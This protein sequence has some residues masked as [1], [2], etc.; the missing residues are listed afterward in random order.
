[1]IRI[2]LSPLALMVAHASIAACHQPARPS[3]ETVAHD[4][5]GTGLTTAVE[6]PSDGS[7]HLEVTPRWLDRHRC[8]VRVID[9]REPEELTGS[10]GHIDGAE[11][12]PI[13]AVP[14]AATSWN[15]GDPI[16]LVCKQG[17]RSHGTAVL[18]ESMGFS[19]VASLAGGME[20]WSRAGLAVSHDRLEMPYASVPLEDSPDWEKREAP[21]WAGS[22]SLSL[23]HVREHF[24]SDDLRWIQV[25]GLLL[26]GHENCVD[27]RED[28]PI[29]GTPGGDAGELLLLLATAERVNH[30]DFDLD[31]RIPALLTDYLDTFGQFYMHTDTHALENLLHALH[32]DPRFRDHVPAEG[33]MQHAELLVR[34]PP[35][36]LRPALMEHLLRP[37][38]VGCGHLRLILEHPEEY[39][40][41]V[42]L[43][44]AML[45]AVFE[46]LWEQREG[47]EYEV[48]RGSHEEGAIVSV[49]VEGPIRSFTWVPEVRPH[50]LGTQIFI[51]H[52]QVSAHLRRHATLFLI[53][54]EPW[55]HISASQEGAF[56]N[57]LDELAAVQLEAT[58]RHL[59][60]TLPIF[61]VHFDGHGISARQLR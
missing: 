29:I 6:F 47:L 23:Q 25:G 37:S 42:E 15:R 50:V 22:S 51:N 43:I 41:R 19:R 57:A 55:M 11:A 17:R 31:R 3:E 10:V 40:V 16:V 33:D 28:H 48:L 27:G 1:M 12:V 5:N 18:L 8:G 35:E 36:S 46:A 32:Q 60:P 54:R 30:P 20:G 14:R 34:H 49:T 56:L 45:R 13:L 59:A 4:C 58:V 9:L 52:P 61:D 53:D 7:L 2:S 24:E 38:N 44:E 21:S 39:E 26:R